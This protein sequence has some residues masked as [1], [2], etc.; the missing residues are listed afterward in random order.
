MT[1]SHPKGPRLFIDNLGLLLEGPLPK[2][3]PLPD[4]ITHYLADVLRVQPDSALELCDP[5]KQALYHATVLAVSSHITVRIESTTLTTKDTKPALHLFF[6]LCKG[7]R[8]DLICDW[9][10]ELGCCGI[11]FWQATRSIVRL[12]DS[13]DISRK[14]ERFEKIARAASQQSKRPSLPII[15]VSPSLASSLDLIVK[16]SPQNS[17]PHIGLFGALTP[18]APTLRSLEGQFTSSKNISIV[19]GPEGDFTEAEIVLLKEQGFFP[20]SLGPQTLRSELAA[21]TCIIAVNAAMPFAY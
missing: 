18:H 10:T 21:I 8:N 3:V 19:I 1:I 15:S 4:S 16:L 14:R 9:A 17:A 2:T 20:I 7:E 13:S 11:H 5:E 6:A 12:K